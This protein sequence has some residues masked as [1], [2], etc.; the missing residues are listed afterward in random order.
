MGGFIPPDMKG[1]LFMKIEDKKFLKELQHEMLTQDNVGQANPRFWVVKQTEKEYWVADGEEGIFVYSSN[2]AESV[3]EGSTNEE[4]TEWLKELDGVQNC[5]VKEFSV[6]LELEGI[7]YSI[8][9]QEDLQEFL[10]DYDDGNYSVGAYKNKEVI[11]E[12]T[13]FLT[14]R[15]CEEH[16]KANYYHY[17]STVH[18]YAMTAWRSPQVARLYKILEETNWDEV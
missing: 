6:K 17:N 9:D 4:L 1:W 7:P 18:P 2:D 3:Y 11:K 14:L 8:Y 16:I 13:M 10:N 12:N 5:E 15:E